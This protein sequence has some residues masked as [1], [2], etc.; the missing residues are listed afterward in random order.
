MDFD[1]F[2]KGFEKIAVVVSVERKADGAQGAIRLVAGNTPYIRMVA[3]RGSKF[4]PGMLYTDGMSRDINFESM[5]MR[6]VTE[7]Q[8]IHSYVRA[9]HFGGW[10][11]LFMMPLAVAGEGLDYL[12][13]SVEMMAAVEPDRLADFSADMAEHVLKICIRLRET[14]D[15]Q[16]AMNSVIGDIQEMC[17]S[18]HCC[19]LLT[20]FEKRKCS[21]HCEA[22]REGSGLL[23]MGHY[24]D[25]AF[26]D[27]AGSWIETIGNSNCVAVA[28]EQDMKRLAEVNPV[29]AASLRGAG[30]ESVVLYPLKSN[31][32]YIGFIWAINFATE[33]VVEIKEILEVTTFILSSEVASYQ[34]YKKLEKLSRVDLLTGVMNR[35]TMNNRID[36]IVDDP[37]SAEKYFGVIFADINGLKRRNDTEGHPSGDRLLQA[38][39]ES[40]KEVF[41]DHEIYRAGGDEFLILAEKLSGKELKELADRVREEAALN[42]GVSFSVGYASGKGA[43]GLR[44]ALGE[45]DRRMYEDKE[46][47]YELHPDLDRRM[48]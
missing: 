17:G 12:L 19:I 32:Q 4:I 6:C 13:F 48:R 33:R 28:D 8:A 42:N 7:K 34:M 16:A 36:E 18:N 37:A 41:A 15:F 3:T 27:I 24:V 44:R 38:A 31:G 2:V 25:D 10:L 47:Y 1:A 40:L 14:D 23:P 9:E 26:I 45:A 5:C 20:A 43:L 46:R 21:V 35:N 39:S 29:W 11:S 22:I 30:A